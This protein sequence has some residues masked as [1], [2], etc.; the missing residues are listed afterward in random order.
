MGASGASGGSGRKRGE[1]VQRGWPPPFVPPLVFVFVD[2]DELERPEVSALRLVLLPQAAN[3]EAVI[4]VTASRVRI[5][6]IFFM[7]ASR[8]VEITSL[9]S[10]R[11]RP[12]PG[13]PG[14]SER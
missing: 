6:A 3:A 2:E 7:G 1:R 14:G 9:A 11:A 8:I 13:F 4:E 12:L 5:A 10:L